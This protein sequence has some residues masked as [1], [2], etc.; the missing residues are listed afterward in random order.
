VL[1]IFT[2]FHTGDFRSL[3]AAAARLSEIAD[4]EEQ[5]FHILQQA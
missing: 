5:A 3:E 4:L 1:Y 2:I